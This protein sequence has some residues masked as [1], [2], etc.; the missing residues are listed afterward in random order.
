MAMV[1]LRSTRR[2]A[3]SMIWIWMYLYPEKKQ[4]VVHSVYQLHFLV[5]HVHVIWCNHVVY[6]TEEVPSN[7][8]IHIYTTFVDNA[9]TSHWLP[10][11]K[12][13]LSTVSLETTQHSGSQTTPHPTCRRCFQHWETVRTVALILKKRKSTNPKD[14]PVLASEAF[15]LYIYIYVFRLNPMDYSWIISWI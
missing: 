6:L 12:H 9:L 15:I 2:A 14:P 5:A 13:N 3:K 8:K 7:N 1:I 11:Q 4:G 10:G